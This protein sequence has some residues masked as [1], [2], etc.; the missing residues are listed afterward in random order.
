MDI[1]EGVSLVLSGGGAR[2]FFHL[3]VL[4]ALDELKIPVKEISGASIGAIVGAFYLAG[5]SP[6]EIFDFFKSG[7]YKKSFKLNLFGGSLFKVDVEN[8][9]FDEMLGD[10]KN[11]EDLPKPLYVSVTNIQ[12]GSVSYLNKG[13]I[14]KLVL[15]SGALYPLIGKVVVEGEY[16]I[17][18]GVMDNFPISPL[19][20]TKYPLIGSNLH[21]NIYQP[22]QSVFVRAFFLASLARGLEDKIKLC[23]YYLAPKELVGRSI[24]SLKN[25]DKL[26]KLGYDEAKKAL[27]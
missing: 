10:V 19:K 3:G 23:D 8:K 15:A 12:Q 24:F 11:L 1:K 18:G 2:G 7:R 13:D 20:G 17:D 6:I 27:S 26:F 4:Q 25:A 5:N 22:K 9:I 21:P 14:K 16:L